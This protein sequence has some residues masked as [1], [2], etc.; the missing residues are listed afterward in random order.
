[1]TGLALAR[2]FV[3]LLLHAGGRDTLWRLGAAA[4]FMIA[5]F[6]D[7]LD[8]QLARERGLITDFGKIADPIADKALM[9]S[10]L[11][12]LSALGR[13]WWW[14]TIVILVRELAITLLLASWVKYCVIAASQA[15]QLK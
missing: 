7:R 1:M 11:V 12:A 13:L 8:G 6:T 2:V 3:V 4:V 15:G 9:G 14:V 5:S 10:A